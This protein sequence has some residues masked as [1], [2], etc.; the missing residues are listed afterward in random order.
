[1]ARLST[2]H[3][4]QQPVL[5]QDF[6]G[7][8]NTSNAS[9][10]IQ[11]NELSVSINV[12]ID[13][14]TGLLR[15]VAGTVTLLETEGAGF[16]DFAY[17]KLGEAFII[18]SED[19]TVRAWDGESL[20]TAGNLTGVKTPSFHLWEDGVLIASGGKMQY[21][22]GGTLETIDESPEVC[23]GV[24]VKDG[25]V[26]TYYEDRLHVSAVGDEHSWENDS[27]I[28]SSSQWVDIGYKD[29]GHIVG[30]VALSSDVLIIKSNG[31]VFHL[32]GQFPGWTVREVSRE[33]SCKGLRSSLAI[34][35]EAIILGDSLMQA[36]STTDTYGDM[37]AREISTKV[38]NDIA[39]LPKDVKLRYIPTLNQIWLVDGSRRFLFL[40]M[41]CGG[42]YEREYN[43]PLMDACTVGDDVYILKPDKLQKLDDASV[44][45]EGELM[46]WHWRGKTLVAN[47]EY[48]VKRGRADITPLTDNFFDCRFWIGKAVLKGTFPR[49]AQS[50]FHDYSPI[51]LNDRELW[52][53]SPAPVYEN[54]P[55]LYGNSEYLFGN[56]TELYS[57]NLFRTDERFVERLRGVKVESIGQGGQLLFNGLGFDMAEV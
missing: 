35:N 9:E 14:S 8:L 42:Y 53:P 55:E 56:E 16:T 22:H 34:V 25:R 37:R 1:M 33:V 38:R 19:G 7:G 57:L 15:T 29:G 43:S 40:D 4:N 24:F 11:P 49:S 12:E 27:S 39:R 50:V 51:Y 5:Y 26:W 45:D 2:K 44:W 3:A 46:R 54:S 17:D 31:H 48:L 32:A 21:F 6:S 20:S 23:D 47:N 28:L 13:K 52:S 10:M 18:C 41:D 36:V 30:V